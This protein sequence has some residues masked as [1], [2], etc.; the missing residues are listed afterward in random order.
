MRSGCVVI[1]PWH[2]HAVAAGAVRPT[3]RGV[4]SDVAD[5]SDV[6]KIAGN[7][8]PAALAMV[9]IVV[10]KVDIMDRIGIPAIA[11]DL[12]AGCVPGRRTGCAHFPPDHGPIRGVY[13][14]DTR[15]SRPIH[16]ATSKSCAFE[17]HDIAD[18]GTA[19][20]CGIDC[21]C[22]IGAR[23]CLNHIAAGQP[24]M[25]RRGPRRGRG[26]AV[27]AGAATGGHVASRPE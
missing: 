19:S 3:C 4:V 25:V 17:P 20:H 23:R 13:F 11:I 26:E 6:I 7:R 8:K 14:D 24:G 1:L 18:C 22:R 27:V 10:H 2:P 12:K 5:Q 16:L 21:K 15:R 9:R